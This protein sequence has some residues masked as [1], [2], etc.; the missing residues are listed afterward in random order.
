MREYIVKI[1]NDNTVTDVAAPQ[2][3]MEEHNATQLTIELSDEL[4]HPSI[5]YYTLCFNMNPLTDN[6]YNVKITSDMISSDTPTGCTDGDYIY[7]PLPDSLTACKSLAVQVQAYVLA[8]NGKI[9]EIIKSPVFYLNF[10]SSVTGEEELLSFDGS[11]FVSMIHEAISQMDATTKEADSLCEKI[12]TA[13]ENGEMNGST[14]Y[15]EISEDG[16]LTWTNDGGFD[17]P[18]SFLNKGEPGLNATINGCEA[19]NITAGENISLEQNGNELRISA[20]IIGIE[21]ALANLQ[22]R[23][24]SFEAE[25]ITIEELIDESGVLK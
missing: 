5:S 14:F 7:Y 3:Y 12:N 2:Q 19:L 16:E 15:P 22:M 20:D 23:F 4:K 17:N 1:N 24:D 21:I 25:A 8:A 13:F 6:P 18:P 10:G 11:G 9:D